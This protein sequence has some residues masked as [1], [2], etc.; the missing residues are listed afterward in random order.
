MKIQINA[1]N[2]SHDEVSYLAEIATP[3]TVTL[4]IGERLV[5]YEVDERDGVRLKGDTGSPEHNE[6]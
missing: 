4:E 2:P 5:M 1:K 3:C 6:V